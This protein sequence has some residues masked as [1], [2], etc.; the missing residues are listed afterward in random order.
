M[1]IARQQF[2]K[3]RPMQLPWVVCLSKNLVD[4]RTAGIFLLLFWCGSATPKNTSI[5]TTVRV[6][7]ITANECGQCGCFGG[8]VPTGLFRRS[9]DPC[10]FHGSFFCDVGGITPCRVVKLHGTTYQLPVS[11]M[12]ILCN[13]ISPLEKNLNIG[14]NNMEYL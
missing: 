11:K 2:D 4:A 9:H 5:R 14:Y 3:R 1:P 12:K 8:K 7:G 10:S 13:F 6:G